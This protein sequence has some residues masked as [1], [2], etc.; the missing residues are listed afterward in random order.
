MN[1]LKKRA[2]TVLVIAESDPSGSAGLQGDL[3]TLAA[4]G[5]YGMAVPTSLNVRGAQKATQVHPI[6]AKITLA[7]IRAVLEEMPVDA[8]KVGALHDAATAVAV[9]K[10]LR[11]F[12]GP[13]IVD[14]VTH[15]VQ[16][17]RFS[18]KSLRD[19]LLDELVPMASVLTPN[20]NAATALCGTSIRDLEMMISAAC[21]LVG[22]GASCV[23][24]KGGGLS[25]DPVDVLVEGANFSLLWG[26]RMVLKRTRGGGSA[27]STAISANMA[28]GYD[29]R[30][31]CIDAR[32]RLD[33]ALVTDH[34]IGRGTPSLPHHAMRHL[35][36]AEKN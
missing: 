29:A 22:V 1:T 7:S 21:A 27:I 6:D 20:L 24:L 31:A 15:R 17:Q 11:N 23:M 16:R 4:L 12:S 32:L 34:P 28:R 13:I 3:S 19:Q 33:R 35:K 5:L 25:G 18:E 26:Q 36:S 30:T 14:P 8:I 9:A 10:A 2:A